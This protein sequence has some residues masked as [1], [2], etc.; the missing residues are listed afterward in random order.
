ML[1]SNLSTRPFYN[2]R[3][4]HL[5]LALAAVFVLAFTV[6][7]IGGIVSLSRDNTGLAL[8]ASDEES[9]AREQRAAAQRTRARLD[10]KAIAAVSA[11]A[12][13]ANAIIDRRLFSWTALFNYFETTLPDDVRITSVRPQTD[14]AGNVKISMTVIGRRVEEVDRFM[15]ALEATRAFRN[16]LS[17][18]ERTTENDD[19]LAVVDGEYLP[20]RSAPPGEAAPPSLGDAPANRQQ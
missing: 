8:R 1:R 2:E 11:S 6:L 19:L 7:N 3:A 13:E 20:S 10:P 9:G 17:I 18:D 16:V 14:A 5:L 15:D 4:V 12:H